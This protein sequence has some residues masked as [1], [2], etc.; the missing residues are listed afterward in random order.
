MAKRGAM[1]KRNAFTLIEVLVTTILVSVAVVAV[2]GALR[3]LTRSEIRA[4]EAELLQRLAVQKLSELGTVTDPKTSDN[5]GDF[6]E[7]GYADASWTLTIEPGS[8]TDIE[9]ATVTATR[10]DVEQTLVGLIFVRPTTITTSATGA[11][12]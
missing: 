1:A 6:S 7:Q 11:T 3:S 10:G 9:Q 4:R 2:F 12:P 5:K 8:L